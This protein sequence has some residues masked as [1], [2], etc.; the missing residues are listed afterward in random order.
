MRNMYTVQKS[1]GVVPCKYFQ[2]HGRQTL[3]E[4]K[5]QVIAAMHVTKEWNLDAYP[6]L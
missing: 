4:E 2:R 5:D 3:K 1:L 6:V